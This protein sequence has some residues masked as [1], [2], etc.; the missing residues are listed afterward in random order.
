[1]TTT[2]L[3]EIASLLA[4]RA[5]HAARHRVRLERRP[6]VLSL[7]AIDALEASWNREFEIASEMAFP[8][9]AV[10]ESISPDA[11]GEMLV[12]EML[13][14]VWTAFIYLVDDDGRGEVRPHRIASAI[15]TT[16]LAHR[17]RTLT[18]LV[19]DT[20]LSSHQVRLDRI[21]RIVERWTD[22]LLSAF[23]TCP[24]AKL[25]RFDESRAAD[26]A[27]MWACSGCGVLDNEPI[28]VAAMRAAVPAIPV[29]N[30]ARATAYRE[31]MGAVLKSVGDEMFAE[32][33][34]MKSTRRR[35]IERCGLDEAPRGAGPMGQW[36]R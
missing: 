18:A 12:G 14:R 3:V 17:R 21:R 9:D 32:S 27:E 33:G 6:L 13:L 30:S 22:V 11:I 8:N 15:T 35:L 31:L 20:T 28:V 5:R 34:A 26:Y 36:P 24:A 25:L 23:P 1:V 4:L 7:R 29:G 10:P 19:S 2:E 16:L